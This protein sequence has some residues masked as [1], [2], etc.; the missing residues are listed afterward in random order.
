MGIKVKT[1][2]KLKESVKKVKDSIR[3]ESFD[4]LIEAI[5]NVIR[6][7][8]S[9]VEGAGRFTRYSES[10]R[11][12]IKKGYE[13]VSDKQGKVSPV[14]MTLS[15][16]MLRSLKSKPGDEGRVLE[17]E[18]EKADYHN[19]QGAGKA[20]TIRRLLPTENGEKFSNVVQNKFVKAVKDLV[21]KIRF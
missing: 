12:A 2:L 14:D 1:T 16:D 21:K 15:G 17:F 6:K 5:K 9:P 3:R 20:K 4:E 8:I 13:V 18:D 11:D 19:N 10:Y 7:G